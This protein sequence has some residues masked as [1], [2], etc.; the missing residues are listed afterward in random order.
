MTDLLRAVVVPLHTE[1]SSALYAAVTPKGR[2]LKEYVFRAD[3]GATK[4]DIRRAIE[5]LFGVHVVHIR[6]LVQRAR[7]K[8]RGRTHGI[9]PRWKKAYVRLKEGETIPGVFEG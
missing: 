8:T 7:V 2:A 6:T 5:T 4:S 1:K 3:A 9:R